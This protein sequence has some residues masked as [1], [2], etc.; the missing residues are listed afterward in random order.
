MR[1][2]R[3]FDKPFRCDPTLQRTSETSS[4]PTRLFM[5]TNYCYLVE[6]FGIFGKFWLGG[7]VFEPSGGGKK[8]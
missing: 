2:C 1:K 5:T 6:N 8:V 4:L 3:S 7:V